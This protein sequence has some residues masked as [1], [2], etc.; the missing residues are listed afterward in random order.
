MDWRQA[1]RI[2]VK[3]A[4]DNGEPMKIGWPRERV[5][6][7]IVAVATDLFIFRYYVAYYIH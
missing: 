5:D 4:K 2:V 3:W 6:L 7:L 1:A